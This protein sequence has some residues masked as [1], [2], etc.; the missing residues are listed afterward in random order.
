MALDACTSMKG[1]FGRMLEGKVP[2]EV[3]AESEKKGWLE[4]RVDDGRPVKSFTDGVP[5]KI[6]ITLPASSPWF[7]LEVGGQRFRQTVISP[8]T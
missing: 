6:S 7:E 1:W 8:I 4:R 5:A 2:Q 3:A